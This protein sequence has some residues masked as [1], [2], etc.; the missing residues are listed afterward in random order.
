MIVISVEELSDRV[1][2]LA[3]VVEASNLSSVASAVENLLFDYLQWKV[4]CGGKVDL[5]TE[6]DRNDNSNTQNDIDKDYI[7]KVA[8]QRLHRK[9]P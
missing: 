5:G 2:T 6:K 3:Q 8:L 4:N 9:L 1:E 7:V